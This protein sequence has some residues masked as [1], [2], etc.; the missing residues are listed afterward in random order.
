MTKEG[1]ILMTALLLAAT[2]AWAQIDPVLIAQGEKV[3]MEKKC[4]SCHMINGK[5][6]TVGPLARGPDLSTVGAKRDAQW[7]KTF[8]KDPKAVNSKAKM[9]PF[10][11][12][13]EE[14]E[15]LAAYLGSLK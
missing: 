7:L 8:L 12:S 15:L 1:L 10:R 11:G 13:E 5:G 2:G 14:L 9:M 4:A 3:Y 6:G